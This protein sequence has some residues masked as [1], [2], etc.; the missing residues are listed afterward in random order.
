MT[1]YN[2][3]VGYNP[4]LNVPT[5]AVERDPDGGQ[6]T[7]RMGQAVGRGRGDARTRPGGEES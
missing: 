1:P 3:R 5:R 2:C 7:L 4:I 6:Q